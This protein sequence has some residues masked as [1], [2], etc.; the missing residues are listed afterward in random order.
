MECLKKHKNNPTKP[1]WNFSQ[2]IRL[3]GN[4]SVKFRSNNAEGFTT[5]ETHTLVNTHT[6]TLGGSEQGDV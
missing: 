2:L 3:V 1:N 4:R 6:H 5:E